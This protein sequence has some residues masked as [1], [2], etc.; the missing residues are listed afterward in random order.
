MTLAATSAAVWGQQGESDIGLRDD[1][2]DEGGR[3]RDVIHRVAGKRI[4]Q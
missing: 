3:P 4:P 1:R 2:G